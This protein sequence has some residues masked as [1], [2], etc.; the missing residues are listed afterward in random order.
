MLS[1]LFIIPIIGSMILILSKNEF[2]MKIIAL[3]TSLINLVLSLIL[4]IQ[5]DENSHEFQF[6]QE[7]SSIG[8]CHFHVGVDGIS[9][10]FI[11]LTTF[12]T[13]IS[14]L[15]SWSS[16]KKNL[17][18]FLIAFL[19]M[20]SLLIGV[21]IVL[22]L[23]LFYITFES[24]LIPMVLIIGIF[25]SGKRKIK[26]VFYLFLYT[27]AGSFLMLLSILFILSITGT[28]DLQSLYLIQFSANPQ[29][30]IWLGFL[31]A[32][33]I[34]TPLV[35]LHVW[36]NFAHTNA[37]LGGSI[38]LAGVLL[39]L[40][41]YG[42]IRIMPIFPE[43]HIYFT[44]MVVTFSLISIIYASFSTLRQIDIKSIVAYSSIP[45]MSVC[46]LGLFSN[47][48]QGIEGALFL[49]LAHGLTS[50]ALFILVTL[51]YDRHGT[52]VIKYYKGLVT[53]M[54]IFTIFFFIFTLANMGTPLTANWIGEFLSF[55][56]AFQM[57]PILTTIAGFSMV[58]SAGYSIWFFNRVS[59]KWDQKF[60]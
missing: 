20:E 52:R 30:I 41:I 28:T 3:N 26:A 15:A 21:F 57:N 37:P 7:W 56:G 36:L 40:A 17:K 10:F 25:G 35:P 32:F 58:I 33:S 27:L 19:I 51:L 44:P 53:S 11:I 1:L 29:Y 47:T 31:L 48:V 13:T 34:K 39:K 9:L 2:K 12:I 43:A 16:I 45:H 49:S 8:F 22:D 23:L 42:F 46:L 24:S 54:P 18:Y 6:V 38:I 14:I 4:W 55:M 60:L 50:P 59:S 5:F